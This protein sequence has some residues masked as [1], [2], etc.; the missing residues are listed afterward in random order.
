MHSSDFSTKG[1]L[2]DDKREKPKSYLFSKLVAVPFPS[3]IYLTLSSQRQFSLVAV[4][5]K[6]LLY[7]VIYSVSEHLEDKNIVIFIISRVD[8]FYSLIV[9]MDYLHRI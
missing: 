2:T 5:A 9:L 8:K 7:K 6:A 4:K 1:K 3:N